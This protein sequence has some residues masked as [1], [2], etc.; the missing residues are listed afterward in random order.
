MLRQLYIV[1]YVLLFDMLS[2]GVYCWTQTTQFEI[3]FDRNMNCI[4]MVTV[5][6]S[7]IVLTV[8]I[9]ELL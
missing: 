7:I 8:I 2:D 5:V 3:T 4:V 1:W 9:V 6:V